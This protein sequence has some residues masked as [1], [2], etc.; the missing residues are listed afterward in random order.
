LTDGTSIVETVTE[1]EEN[2][3]IHLVGS[4]FKMPLESLE[5]EFTFEQVDSGSKTRATCE[6]QYVVKF[7]PIGRLLGEVLMKPMLTSAAEKVLLGAE[8]HLLTKETVGPN[9]ALPGSGSSSSALIGAV[10]VGIA[11]VCYYWTYM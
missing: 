1:V 2:S 3:R 4:E 5:L 7:G 6:I 8:H 10:A 9:T 11:A